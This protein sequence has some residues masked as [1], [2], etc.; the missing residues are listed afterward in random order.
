MVNRGLTI[1]GS[2]LL[3]GSILVPILFLGIAAETGGWEDIVV[4]IVL[5]FIL[6]P[7]AF[8]VGLVLLIVGLSRGRQQQ[9][10]QVV[11]VQGGGASRFCT[12]CGSPRA[13]GAP[14]CPGCGQAA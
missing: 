9:Q 5:T 11:I 4:G 6:A 12:H 10:Q 7:I 13:G 8:I 2:S 1:A 3:V 14:F